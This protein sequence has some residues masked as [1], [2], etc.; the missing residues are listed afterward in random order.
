LAAEAIPVVNRRAVGGSTGAKIAKSPAI[1]RAEAL[2]QSARIL[3][4]E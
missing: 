2:G 1:R 4:C 3:R